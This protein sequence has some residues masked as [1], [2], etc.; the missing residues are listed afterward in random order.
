MPT[1]RAG[2]ILSDEVRSKLTSFRKLDP[3]GLYGQFP[4]ITNGFQTF[5]ASIASMLVEADEI[6]RTILDTPEFTLLKEHLGEKRYRASAAQSLD[7]LF[8]RKEGA[9]QVF[10]LWSIQQHNINR[11]LILAL[12]DRKLTL[13]TSEYVYQTQHMNTGFHWY[14]IL[15]DMEAQ[16]ADSYRLHQALTVLSNP[17]SAWHYLI[18]RAYSIE[19][20]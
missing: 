5:Q 11:N 12:I 3:D 15:S 14:R 6:I 20:G 8:F 2:R 17:Q 9:K 7:E 1:I 18:A 16:E 10:V 4:T 19:M 13:C